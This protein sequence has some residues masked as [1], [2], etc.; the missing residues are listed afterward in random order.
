MELLT[1]TPTPV[2]AIPTSSSR[3]YVSRR[4]RSRSS[5]SSA[6]STKATAGL[7]SLLIVA[8]LVSLAIIAATLTNEGGSSETAQTASAAIPDSPA[9]R[10]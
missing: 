2:P 3:P 5:D 1:F 9:N 8:L 6:L 7:L 4:K 10:E